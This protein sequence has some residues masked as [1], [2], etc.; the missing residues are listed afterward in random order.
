MEEE[1]EADVQEVQHPFVFQY[2]VSND[3]QNF[4]RHVSRWGGK[5]KALSWPL[6]SFHR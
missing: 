5:Q 1:H 3:T 2:G 4:N 6:V